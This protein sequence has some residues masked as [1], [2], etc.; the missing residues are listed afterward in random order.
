[1][2][3]YVDTLNVSTNVDTPPQ[4]QSVEG[5]SRP[6]T[7]RTS[8]APRPPATL[9]LDPRGRSAPRPSCVLQRRRVDTDVHPPARSG[10]G[11]LLARGC[12]ANAAG[13]TLGEVAAARHAFE[14]LLAAEAQGRDPA[15]SPRVRDRHPSTAGR[16]GEPTPG[17][18]TAQRRSIV[19]ES[20]GC[21]Q[22]T[23]IDGLAPRTSS[24]PIGSNWTPGVKLDPVRPLHR[25]PE[26]WHLQDV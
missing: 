11:G 6:L 9:R 15:G 4:V 26:L 17:R 14:G 23:E 10:L 7:A 13:V 12:L 3:M 22:S 21:E 24:R 19:L 2:S 20:T 16:E 18:T 8:T 25:F 5:T 1:M